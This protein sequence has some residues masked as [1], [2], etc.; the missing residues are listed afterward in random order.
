MTLTLIYDPVDGT[1]VRDNDLENLVE[2]WIKNPDTTYTTSSFLAVLKLGTRLDKEPGEV[3]AKLLFR[4]VQG[5]GL[6]EIPFSASEFE[7]PQEFK[8]YINSLMGQIFG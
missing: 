4:S 1:P 7:L 5:N 3:E 8:D 2:T 6:I